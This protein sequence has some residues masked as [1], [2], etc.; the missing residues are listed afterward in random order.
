MEITLVSIALAIPNIDWSKRSKVILAN[1]EVM[2]LI[3]GGDPQLHSL[4]RALPQA[5]LHLST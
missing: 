4:E 1:L 3:G 2:S 5:A